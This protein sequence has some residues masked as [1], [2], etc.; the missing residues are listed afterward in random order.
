[1]GATASWLADVFV[2]VLKL[3]NV[4]QRRSLKQYNTNQLYC[5]NRA[6]D[7]IGVIG[8]AYCIVLQLRIYANTFKCSE[9]P[10]HCLQSLTI[11]PNTLLLDTLAKGSDSECG[12]KNSGNSFFIVIIQTSII[13]IFRQEWACQQCSLDLTPF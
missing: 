8:A 9:L 10:Q 12:S 5:I 2:R 3:V 4:K 6:S 11:S 1:M 7:I 13:A